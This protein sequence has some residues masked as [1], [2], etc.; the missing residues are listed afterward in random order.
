MPATSSRPPA[1]VARPRS[2]RRGLRWERQR[3]AGLTENSLASRSL[4]FDSGANEASRKSARPGGSCRRGLPPPRRPIALPRR[5]TATGVRI[6]AAGRRGLPPPRRPI[7]LRRRGTA[8]GARIPA[9]V[10]H[11][12]S[13]PRR[14]T[15]LPCGGLGANGRI[16]AA[17]RR[18]FSPARRFSTPA[19]AVCRRRATA[20]P[21]PD[22]VLLLR[23][24]CAT[25]AGAVCRWREHAPGHP[26]TALP[27][28]C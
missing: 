22:A 20:G 6:P 18:G 25:P 5:G 28:G 3:P 7:A 24:K 12:S 26:D 11:G 13:P 27:R 9:A 4:G 15:A 16:F 1:A 8:T 19:N 21:Q 2:A 17:V 10:R 23:C 14:P